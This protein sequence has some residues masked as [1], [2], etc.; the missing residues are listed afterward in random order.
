MVVNIVQV[1]L[2][3]VIKDNLT[4]KRQTKVLLEKVLYYLLHILQ[5]NNQ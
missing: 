3:L 5:I 4:L 2:K 1:R